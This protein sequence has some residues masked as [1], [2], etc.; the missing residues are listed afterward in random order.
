[1][2]F[3]ANLVGAL[4]PAH[5]LEFGSGFST[6]VLA[7][8]C[9]ATAPPGSVTSI[10]SDPTFARK[11]LASLDVA[12]GA[13]SV[14]LQL[15][16]LV[17]RYREGHPLPVYD[18]QRG[19]LASPRPA[20]LVLIDGPPAVVGSRSGA[21]FQAMEFVQHGTV[22]LVDDATRCSEA[23]ALDLW[24]QTFADTTERR[25]VS[26]LPNLAIFVVTSDQIPR[27]GWWWLDA[28]TDGSWCA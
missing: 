1:L 20:S 14:V 2:R 26:S 11:T 28:P 6:R 4:R 27:S 19:P 3:L 13:A 5:V 12:P 22:I 10:E 23:A 18:L 16:P 7:R 8:A 9:A 15:A 25:T 17:V 21:L 24:R